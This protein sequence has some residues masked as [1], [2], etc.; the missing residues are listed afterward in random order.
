MKVCIVGAGF[1]GCYF[2]RAIE[3]RWREKVRIDIFDRETSPMLRAASN[4][5]SRLHIGFHYPRSRS[6][7]LQTAWGYH[8]FKEEFRNCVHFPHWNLYAIHRN[9][10]T[11]FE[12]YL[13]TM[14]AFGLKY[15]LCGS[16]ALPYFRD[17][18]LLEGVIRVS[19]GVIDLKELQATI[20]AGLRACIYC[21][22]LV[23]EIC[24]DSGMIKVNGMSKG[25][26]DFVI[27]ATYVDPNLG[28]TDSR[29][30]D[31]K[32][33]IAAMALVDAPF[34]E[35]VALTVM[36]GPFVSLYPCGRNLATL[37][38]VSQTP[39]AK[40]ESL[41]ELEAGYSRANLLAQQ[42]GVKEKILSHGEEL[43]AIERGSWR[44]HGLWLS[45]KTKLHDDIGDTRLGALRREGRCIS[46]MC[47][48]LDAVH[49]IAE[50]LL[51]ALA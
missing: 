36:D 27:N 38:S 1:Y 15:E 35:N 39:F 17:P 43:L 14:D 45:P 28:L 19:E 20:L 7:I 24:A 46:V 51:V 2:A 30:F 6:T 11:H 49:E 4:N 47:G 10:L 12:E 31:L 8:A 21:S 25:P 34:G 26:Y 23:T 44:Y 18:S 48:K 40:Y 22:A 29:K 33:E 3:R 9:G 37:S 42:L 41:D 16:E 50:E 5:Q 32:Y 13:R